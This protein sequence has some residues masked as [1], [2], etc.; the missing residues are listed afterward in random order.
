MSSH[1]SLMKSPGDSS[2]VSM[3]WTAREWRVH[4]GAHKTATTHIQDTLALAKD[5]LSAV[6]IEYICRDVTRSQ[7]D[8]C[9]IRWWQKLPAFKAK[10][11]EE[12]RRRLFPSGNNG[13]V[14][15]ISEENIMGSVSGLLKFPLYPDLEQGL[16]TLCLLKG[17]HNI[18][19]YLAIRP[20]DEI[21]PSAYAQQAR[22]AKV[23][24]GDF[25]AIKAR[26]FKTPPSW[27]GVVDRI[28]SVFG[29][30]RLRL[31]VFD[32]Y[33]K[34]PEFFLEQL[35]GGRKNDFERLPPPVS[36]RAP[37]ARA[38]VSLE[39][40]PVGLPR[41]LRKEAAARICLDDDGR[42]PFTP[43]SET[44]KKILAD[45]YKEDLS[46]LRRKYSETFLE[47]SR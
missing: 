39:Q 6:G 22:M 8:F 28:V 32:D 25:D 24:S 46:E 42:E 20:L 15:L 2:A 11:V 7:R 38:I 14:V 37:S 10:Y 30:N 45:I 41:R 29:R 1:I 3:P 18:H 40:I 33:K 13:D 23:H 5:D 12:E 27:T 34:D 17:D 4:I 47:P 31:W 44:E 26:M 19:I 43:F 35:C 21:I 9:R 36:T 16:R